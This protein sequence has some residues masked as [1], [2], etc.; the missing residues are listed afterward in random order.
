MS[1]PHTSVSE[2]LR[3]L[4]FEDN[5]MDASLIT[6]FLQ[7]SGIKRDNIVTTDAIP[8]AMDVLTSKNV[9]ICL[10]DYYLTPNTGFDLMDE[11]RRRDVDVP[12]IMLTAMKDPAV[13]EGAL[14]RGAYDFMIKGEL[15]VENLERTIRYTLARHR[16]ESALSKAA[17]HDPL[18]NLSNRKALMDHLHKVIM[19]P[20]QTGQ[21]MGAVIYVNL[22]GIKFINEAYGMKVGDAIL[23]ETGRRLKAI[24][25]PGEMM[26]RL[27]SD[28]FGCVVDQVDDIGQATVVARRIATAFAQPVRTYDG[29]HDVSVAIGLSAFSRSSATDDP[30][31]NHDT[32][33]DVLQR[34]ANAM[35]EAKR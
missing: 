6:R 15:T 22:N 26:A 19:T 21:A 11:A 9:D 3:I 8:N 29:E 35:A 5:A 13:D 30:V 34:A 33:L 23:R 2:S 16:R 32:N 17:F 18:S 1:Q 28:E 20:P 31:T 12:F 4:L 27:G 14:S 7:A 25:W 24:K 10:T